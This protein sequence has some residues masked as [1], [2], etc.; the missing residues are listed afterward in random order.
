MA[1]TSD[2]VKPGS[3]IGLPYQG[4]HGKAF[5]E[6]GGSDNWQSENACDVW[7]YPG[8]AITAI[9]A[10]VISPGSWGY[11]QSSEGGRFAGS[12]CHL[13]V[14]PPA[15][16]FVCFYTHLQHLA[17][18]KGAH[19]QAGDVIGWSGIANGVPHLHFAVQ[20]GYNPVDY[21]RAAYQ[22]KQHRQAGGSS[23]PP[24]PAPAA[25]SVAHS[26]EDAWHDL[27]RVFAFTWPDAT[28]H[29]KANRDRIHKA[30]N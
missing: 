17:V 5:N 25:G 26:L 4:T 16:P 6:R 23:G 29:V 7:L 1:A 14:K 22:L 27:M 15:A 3:I 9:A 20:P 13:V 30:V 28:A 2:H 24:G 12:R 21:V 19:V 18:D 8:T 11:G 10:G